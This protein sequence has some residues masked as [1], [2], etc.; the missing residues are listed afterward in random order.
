MVRAWYNQLTGQCM[1]KPAS[2]SIDVVQNYQIL[3]RRYSFLSAIYLLE[4][5]G[6]FGLDFLL[7]C[8]VKYIDH[9]LGRVRY[10]DVEPDV[11]ILS[12]LAD[13]I[14]I[15]NAQRDLLE[16]LD[17]AVCKPGSTSFQYHSIIDRLTTYP[18]VPIWG[19]QSSPEILP[20]Q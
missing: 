5:Y 4:L 13:L 10:W 15:F 12:Y 18:F 14:I 20:M 17:D 7:S 3:Y 8:F 19:S 11:V 2:W 9:P 6:V 1:T 16:V